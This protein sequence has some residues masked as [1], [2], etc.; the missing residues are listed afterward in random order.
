[1]LLTTGTNFEGYR[2]KEYLKVLTKEVIFKNGLGK[3]FSAAVT[4]LIDSFTFSDY[5]LTGSTELIN[6]A[7]QHIFNQFI[8]EAED[9]GANAILGIDFETSFG[10]SLFRLSISGTAVIV[11]KEVQT[12]PEHVP[13]LSIPVTMT[14][15]NDAF[16]PVSV[17]LYPA[18]PTQAVSLVL[19][20]PTASNISAVEANLFF[21]NLFE[22]EVAVH[23]VCFMNLQQSGM[24]QY[25]SATF[26]VDLPEHILSCVK[27]CSIQVLKYIE[28]GQVVS[29]PSTEME[30]IEDV[31]P[32]AASAYD[33]DAILRDLSQFKGSHEMI[34][35]LNA[36]DMDQSSDFF[37]MLLQVLKKRFQFERFYGSNQETTLKEVRKAIDE[38]NA[39][40]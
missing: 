13:P 24:R 40:Q 35:Y 19:S 29:V 11:E 25:T 31:F 16:R 10:D 20:Q 36:S 12:A 22:D 2:V 37:Q 30:P 28:N 38:Y 18:K 27:E 6:N 32:S 8:K 9:K 17:Q 26:P 3:S 5:E 1:M 15:S 14:N 34:N 23:Q 4:N 33:A 39:A 7:K 21:K